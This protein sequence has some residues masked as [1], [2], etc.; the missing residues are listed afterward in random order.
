MQ[1][2]KKEKEK[3]K[4]KGKDFCGVIWSVLAENSKKQNNVYSMLLLCLKGRGG[5]DDKQ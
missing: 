3:R 4:E 1:L 5:I 2:P